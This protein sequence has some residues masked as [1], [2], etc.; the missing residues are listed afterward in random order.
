MNFTK[1]FSFKKRVHVNFKILGIFIYDSENYDDF[2]K[3]KT[4][5]FHLNETVT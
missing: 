2:K 4:N 3:Y 1:C 5:N